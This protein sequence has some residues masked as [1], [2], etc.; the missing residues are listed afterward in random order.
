VLVQVARFRAETGEL[1]EAVHDAADALQ[2]LVGDEDDATAAA[3]SASAAYLVFMLSEWTDSS[4]ADVITRGDT[5]TTW[6][7][8]QERAWAY[9]EYFD[10]SFEDWSK[11]DGASRQPRRPR[12]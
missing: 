7:R 2:A 8:S 11:E 5:P 3:L 4:V 12:T 1:T 6:W 9:A 10:A